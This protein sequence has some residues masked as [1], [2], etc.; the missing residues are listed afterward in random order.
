MKKVKTH[1]VKSAALSLL[2]DRSANL[3]E[4]GDRGWGGGRWGIVNSVYITCEEWRYVTGNRSGGNWVSCLR[5]AHCKSTT[6]RM[7][8]AQQF[9]LLSA[10][11]QRAELLRLSMPLRPGAAMVKEV[12]ARIATMVVVVKCMVYWVRGELDFGC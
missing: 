3:L 12:A 6:P 8:T 10:P 7:L 2:P 5:F 4:I 1:S 9:G 11:V